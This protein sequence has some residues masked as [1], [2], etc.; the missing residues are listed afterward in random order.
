MNSS[1]KCH[2]QPVDTLNVP[3]SNTEAIPTNPDTDTVFAGYNGITYMSHNPP[4]MHTVS[5]HVLEKARG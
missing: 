2:F 5:N 4:H 3:Y 1:A